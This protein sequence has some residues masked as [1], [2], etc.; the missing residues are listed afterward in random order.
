[1]LGTTARAH[2]FGHCAKFVLCTLFGIRQR[3]VGSRLLAR[4]ATLRAINRHVARA[5]DPLR[6]II[7]WDA[8]SRCARQWGSLRVLRNPAQKPRRLSSEA[9]AGRKG[10]SAFRAS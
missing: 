5:F 9:L 4:N 1:M 2:R 10:T 8:D 7:A 3:L 6:T